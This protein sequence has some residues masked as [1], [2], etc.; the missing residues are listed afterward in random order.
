MRGRCAPGRLALF[1]AL[2]GA[3]AAPARA[4]DLGHRWDVAVETAKA[5]VGDPVTVRF[6]ISLHERDLLS[7][8]VPRPPDSLPD[9][10]RVLEVE[11]LKRG[12]D[13]TLAGRAKLAFYRPGTQ[14]VP[15]FTLPFVRV[16]AN[17]RG[18]LV[19]DS[20]VTVE[21]APTLPVGNPPLRDIK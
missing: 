11:M 10:V 7:D 6:H 16:T 17:L 19:S 18:N 8:T 21:I 4:Q 20:T 13:R 1:A 9:G 2:V 3:A 5:T 15:S 14:R 12:A